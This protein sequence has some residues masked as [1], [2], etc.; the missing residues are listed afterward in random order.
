MFSFGRFRVSAIRVVI[1]FL[2][3]CIRLI[4]IQIVGSVACHSA[5]ITVASD[6]VLPKATVMSRKVLSQPFVCYCI[7]S[8]CYHTMKCALVVVPPW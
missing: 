6:E 1:M 5:A 4:H 7:L 3:S 2:R 8:V